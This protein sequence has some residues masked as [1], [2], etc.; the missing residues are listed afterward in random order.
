MAAEKLGLP[1][2]RSVSSGVSYEELHAAPGVLRELEQ[3]GLQLRER[4]DG[5]R[6]HVEGGIQLFGCGL[7][8]L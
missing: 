1:E 2:L 7:S 4:S 5:F 8:K 3:S 6:F